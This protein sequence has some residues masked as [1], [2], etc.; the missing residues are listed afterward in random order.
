MGDYISASKIIMKF[1]RK[2]NE[3]LIKKAITIRMIVHKSYTEDGKVFSNYSRKE[4]N[5]TVTYRTFSQLYV[6]FS[7]HCETYTGHKRKI[8][9]MP[10]NNTYCSKLKG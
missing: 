10:V 3:D 2:Y 8:M 5:K 1:W 4:S 6:T 9:P 7:A